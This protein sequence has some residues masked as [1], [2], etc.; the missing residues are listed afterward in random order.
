MNRNTILCENSFIVVVTAVAY[1]LIYTGLASLAKPAYDS[2]GE[3]IDGGMDLETGLSQ[4]DIDL[5]QQSNLIR[6][7]FDILYVT[8]FCQTVSIYTE[9]VWFVW[10]V[11]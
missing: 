9:W 4:Y 6:Y 11:V 10:C 1:F 5:Q 7:Y 2:S 8:W 3:L